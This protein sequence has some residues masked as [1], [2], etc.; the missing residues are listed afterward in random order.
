MP[1]KTPTRKRKSR[2]KKQSDGQDEYIA[3]ELIT[4]VCSGDYLRRLAFMEVLEK[5][6][7][8]EHLTELYKAHQIYKTEWIYHQGTWTREK[9]EAEIEDTTRRFKENLPA[10]LF[11]G[12]LII[13]TQVSASGSAWAPVHKNTIRRLAEHQFLS[14]GK[15]LM[16]DGR[17]RKSKITSYD[18]YSAILKRGADASRKGVAFDLGV[19]EK[20]LDNWRR[21]KDF[22]SW[23]AAIKNAFEVQEKTEKW[24]RE[25]KDS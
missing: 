12:A 6:G 9:W 3:G 25:I 8:V 16:V 1:K 13:A 23:K 17:G 7:L 18:V 21:E 10:G 2:K 20:T 5:S 24:F 11:A 14:K 4:A 19:S 15:Q 22:P